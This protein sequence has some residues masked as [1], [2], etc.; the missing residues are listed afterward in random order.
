[1]LRIRALLVLVAACGGGGGGGGGGDDGLP[2][3]AKRLDAAVDVTELGGDF[4]C[5]GVAWPTTAPDPLSVTGRV[6]DPVAMTNAGGAAV[7]IH[8]AS[9]DSVLAMG[10]AA[11]NGIF[12]FNL[13]TAGAAPTIY[14]K[15]TLAG[16]VDGYTYDPFADYD[17]SQSGRGIYAP[18]PAS[19]DT[20]YAAAGIANDP[21]KGTVLVEILDCTR[22]PV[23]GA[24]VMA[25]GIAKAIYLDDGGAPSATATATGSPGVVVLLGVPPGP[26][27]VTIHAGSV[28]FRTWPIKSTANAFGYSPRL[29]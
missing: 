22:L 5:A 29:P 7:E 23:Y 8:K 28:V 18:T 10:A 16:H 2:G 24:T 27:D 9:D 13:A 20:Y 12:A 21:T 26:I 4:S 14:R 6:T 17:G 25:P 1:M 11:S 19:R 3:D 15:A